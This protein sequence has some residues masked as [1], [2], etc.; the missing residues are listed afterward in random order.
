MRCEPPKTEPRCRRAKSARERAARGSLHDR[1]ADALSTARSSIHRTVPTGWPVR[2]HGTELNACDWAVLLICGSAVRLRRSRADGEPAGMAAAAASGRGPGI[3]RPSAGLA[4]AATAAWTWPAR[5][6]S[7]CTPRAAATV[8]FAGLLA[9]RPV[10]SLAHPGGLHTSY[11]P[12]RAAVRVGQL[13]T[14]RR[15]S[16]SWWPGTRAVRRRRVPA[17]GRDVGSG[18]G[19]RLRGS[20]GS[21]EVNAGPAQAVVWLSACEGNRCAGQSRPAGGPGRAPPAAGIPRHGCTAGWSPGWNGRA[22]PGRRAGQRRPRAGGWPRCAAARAAPCRVPRHRGNGLVHDGA[23][24]PHVEP[25]PARTQQQR[26][27]GLPGCQRWT[28]VGQPAAQRIGGRHPERRAPLLI[29]LAEHPHQPVVGVDVVNVQPAQLAHPD[30]GGIQ[31][32][33]DQPVPQSQRITLLG[34]QTSR[35]TSPAIA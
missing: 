19:R 21:A 20:A 23:G 14:P 30:P 7:R 27:P 4:A 15:C 24:L 9:G 31:H 3:R 13:V 28:P 18:L 26:R 17:L 32:L 11:E 10:V 12:V 33:D 29:A 6:V 5:R 1:T 34:A 8:V 16:A 25:P 22:V 35:L 2:A